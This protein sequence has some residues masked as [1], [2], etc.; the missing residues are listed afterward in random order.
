[1]S[2][3][4]GEMDLLRL[5]DHIFIDKWALTTLSTRVAT[6]GL[7]NSAIRI[8]RFQESETACAL[9]YA[10]EKFRRTLLQDI[11]HFNFWLP[12]YTLPMQTKSFVIV[13]SPLVTLCPFQ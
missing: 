5:S 10:N 1:M 12:Y 4:N 2:M 13:F 6:E 8:G 7:L 3:D 11:F 9:I